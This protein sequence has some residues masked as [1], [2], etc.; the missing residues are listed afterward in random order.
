MI[1]RMKVNMIP[2]RGLDASARADRATKVRRYYNVEG[3][4]AFVHVT[5]LD[6][7]SEFLCPL[8]ITVMRKTDSKHL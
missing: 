3:P 7:R 2:I 4:R 5:P 6:N 1:A 8:K